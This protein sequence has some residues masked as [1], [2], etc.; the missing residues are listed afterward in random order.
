M[1]L[2]E[3]VLGMIS[4]KSISR[5]ATP[6]EEAVAGET[7]EFASELR[8]FLVSGVQ[9]DECLHDFHRD[10]IGFSDDACFGDCVVLN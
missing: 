2:P 10:G 1:I 7:H 3:R 5:G 8:A 4:M 9:G 6:A